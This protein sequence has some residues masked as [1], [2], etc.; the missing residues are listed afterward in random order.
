KRIDD[1]GSSLTKLDDVQNAADF[2]VVWVYSD[3][4]PNELKNVVDHSEKFDSNSDALKHIQRYKSE[5][6]ILLILTDFESLPDYKNL[7]Q[8]QSIY[9]FEK[10][11][12]N[13]QFEKKDH[14]KLVGIFKNIDQLIDRLHKD[15]IL[16]RSD[17]PISFSSLNEIKI[18]HS[19]TNLLGNTL[20]F[21]WNQWI[22]YYMVKPSTMDMDKLREDMLSQCR[23]EYEH[24]QREIE[25]I[26]DFGR[27]CSDD[28][29]LQWY[30]RDSFLYR[31]LNKAFRTRNIEL[32][33]KFQYYIILLYKKFQD[34]SK[35]QQQS[36]SVVY[37]G[38]S[39][40][41]HTITT[42]KSNVGHLISINTI[43]ST[44][45][46]EEVARSFIFGATHG[47]IFKIN[48]QNQT[49]YV[50][51]QF[52]DISHFSSM[53]EEKEILFFAGTIFSI[54]SVKQENVSTWFIE[55]TLKDEVLKHIE[56]LT[57][58]F[59]LFIEFPL[60]K[61]HS[62]IETDDFNM[63]DRYYSM[64]T[65]QI[66]SLKNN[67]TT[68][69]YLYIAFS[70][71]NLGFFER[72]IQFYEQAM[73]V[74]KFSIDS[75]ESKVLH[76]IIGYLYS[77]LSKYDEA[78]IHYGIVLSLLTETDLLTSE[79]YNHIGDVHNKVKND[80]I[81][82]SCYKESLK[83][84]NYQDIP[85][86][87]NIYQNIIGILSKKRNFEDAFVYKEQEKH[88]DQSQYHIS[89]ETLDDP[90][91]LKCRSQLENLSNL[92]PRQRADLLYKIGLCLIKKG[93]FHETLKNLLEAKE[94]FLEES[95]S[96]GLFL[97]R[98][99]RLF[100]NIALLYL[101]LNDHLKALIMWKKTLD[102]RSPFGSY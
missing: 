83:I 98:L 8:I 84:A 102:I 52:I 45:C 55:L 36:P 50:S 26:N 86:L 13:I 5:R 93:D 97:R 6:K 23:L 25:K 90:K 38:Q 34:L 70:F 56:K 85:S 94:L 31:L 16:A 24:D 14:P 48:I 28:N 46:D 33:C 78:F 39:L 65:G 96:W 81:A 68:M 76:I 61:C 87:P 91:L 54:D 9:V 29:I 88:I 35:Q 42:L 62:F 19:L 75:P 12:E 73:S 74:G 66:F 53:S 80:D 72:A 77:H 101:F 79:L 58:E 64:L 69:I 43:M 67:T 89:T 99:P 1:F 59:G 40:N 44:S 30:T 17:L 100:D 47:V 3:D 27:N 4:A 71:S 51:K 95:P 18:E 37:R 60:M 92:T 49:S 15:V 41:K 7:I 57:S 32:I 63:I 11:H 22:F 82:L 20:Q 10:T 21:L 2:I